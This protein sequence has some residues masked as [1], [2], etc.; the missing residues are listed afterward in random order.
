MTVGVTGHRHLAA[1]DRIREGIDEAIEMLHGR[2]RDGGLTLI[3]PLA[4]GSDRLVATRILMRSNARLIVPLPMPVNEYVKDFGTA[5]SRAEFSALLENAA[6]VVT[7]PPTPTRSAAYQAVGR[8]VLDHSDALIAVWDGRP[9]H[10][11]GEV[12]DEARRRNKPIAWVHAGNVDP[13]TG[14]PTSL[15]REQGS[16]TLERF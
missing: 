16:L 12:V 4:E 7:L 5:E 6:E 9:G 13:V 11:T 14:E 2:L 10:G 3:S 1:L 8:Y 15:G